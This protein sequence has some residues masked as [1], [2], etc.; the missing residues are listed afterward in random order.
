[1]LS[2]NFRL[3]TVGNYQWLLQN[4]NFVNL[5]KCLDELV[6]LDVSRNDSNPSLFCEILKDLSGKCFI[7][8]AA[9]GL[10]RSIKDAKLLFA[11]GADKLILNTPI[12]TDKALIKQLASIFGRQSLV[13]SIDVLSQEGTSVL[14]YRH[15]SSQSDLSFQSPELLELLSNYFGEL[16]LNSIAFDGTGQG[17]EL[18]LL[19]ILPPNFSLSVILSGGAGKASHFVDAL[20]D[21][22]VQAVSTAHLF[23]FMGSTLCAARATLKGSN[24]P[25]PDW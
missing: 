6:I 14:K 8:I 11:N 1:M 25:L 4:Y 20:T 19:D 24:I 2:R 17:Y 13:A 23:N 18:T 5:S 15:A 3:Q 12:F 21:S 7:P 9:G 10:I 16:Y 22:R